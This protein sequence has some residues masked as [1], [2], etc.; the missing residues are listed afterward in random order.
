MNER[1]PLFPRAFEVCKL[2]GIKNVVVHP[3]QRGRY[4]GNED[5]LFDLNMRFYSALDPLAI[6]NNVRI[7]IENLWRYHPVTHRIEDDVCAPPEEMNRYFDAIG[8]PD[9]FTLCLDIG[10]V[11]LTNREPD[12]AIRTIGHDRL[13]CVHIH[14]NDYID[15][16][17]YPPGTGKIAWDKVCHA[18]ADIDY[19]GSFNM[20]C[21]RFFFN[22]P[23]EFYPAVA[24]FMVDTARVFADKVDLYRP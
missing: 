3:I 18:L 15:D 14:D 2:L 23:E 13:G 24:K 7:A 6:S 12:V 11:S 19:R 21:D 4:L 20:E 17:H 10:H 16:M 8:D 9:V 22:Y 1:V 5:R